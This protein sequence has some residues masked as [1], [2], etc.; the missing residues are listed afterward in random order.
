MSCQARGNSPWAEKALQDTFGAAYK[1][2]VTTVEA[3]QAATLGATSVLIRKEEAPAD[4]DFNMQVARTLTVT[5]LYR[6]QAIAGAELQRSIDADTDY[7]CQFDAEDQTF[8]N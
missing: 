3:V 4:D 1:A 7:E 6:N 5:H 8:E 2:R